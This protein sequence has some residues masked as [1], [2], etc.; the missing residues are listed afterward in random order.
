MLEC[1]ST[2][3][4]QPRDVREAVTQHFLDH[5]QPLAEMCGF[6]DH[7]LAP[8]D[9][10]LAFEPAPLPSRNVRVTWRSLRHEGTF[11]TA[12]HP[13]SGTLELELH[14]DRIGEAALT[15]E[16]VCVALD[17]WTMISPS[18]KARVK[19][20]FLSR[21]CRASEG[22]T[23]EKRDFFARNYCEGIYELEVGLPFPGDLL[24]GRRHFVLTW[25]GSLH[26]RKLNVSWDGITD[27]FVF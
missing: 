18:L 9:Y 3:R 6:F 19:G 16:D 14:Q 22:L 2:W 24:V 7:R 15:R 23:D 12:W 27:T 10:E 21:F 26:S 13:E 11:R 20:Y 4:N 8:A 25:R 17:A 5:A 1:V